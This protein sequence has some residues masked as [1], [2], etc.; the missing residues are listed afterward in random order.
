[1][2]WDKLSGETEVED[3]DGV[4]EHF[5]IVRSKGGCQRRPH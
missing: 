1:M 5:A 4:G 2:L 3:G